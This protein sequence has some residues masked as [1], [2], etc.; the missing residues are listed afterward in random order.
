MTRHLLFYLYPKFRSCW[1]WHIERLAKYSSVFTGRRVIMAALDK[2][3]E[4]KDTVERAVEKVAATV[5]YV[6]N[7]PA[8]AESAHLSAGLQQFAG[9]A[10]N[11]FY[12][13]AKGVTHTWYL[14]NVLA[15][16]DGMYLLNLEDPEL[17]DRLLTRYKAVGAFRLTGWHGGAHW[18]YS[19]SFFWLRLNAALQAQVL[20]Q[21]PDRY[22]VEGF[23]GRAVSFEESFSLT[24][25]EILKNLYQETLDLES[26]RKWLDAIKSEN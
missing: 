11:L 2:D 15:W 4:S 9:E 24:S 1:E 21:M 13:H 12:A 8:M 22:S 16:A 10:G 25:P 6:D 5:M 20:P 14:H 23:P 18:H 17:I 3:S 26:C 7:L 19:G